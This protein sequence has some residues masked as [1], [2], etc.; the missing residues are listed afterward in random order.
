MIKNNLLLKL[1]SLL[2]VPAEKWHEQGVSLKARSANSDGQVYSGITSNGTYFY[3]KYEFVDGSFTG[4]QE[5]VI[6]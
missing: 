3:R 1:N 5:F 2:D 6:Q 4:K